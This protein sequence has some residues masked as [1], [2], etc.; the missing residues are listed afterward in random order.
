MASVPRTL[1]PVSISA[2][3]LQRRLSSAGPARTRRRI[4][5]RV[6]PIEIRRHNI[7]AL[8]TRCHFL[9]AFTSQSYFDGA[10]ISPAAEV[11]RCRFL[12]TRLCSRRKR[13]FRFSMRI[14][15]RTA[16][17]DFVVKA[18]RHSAR[19]TPHHRACSSCRALLRAFDGFC[20]A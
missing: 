1:T 16:G 13:L 3:C 7:F 10:A 12:I 6:V 15:G 14:E 18:S 2:L 4:A 9:D 19:P 17:A 8:V 5:P 11:A 20:R